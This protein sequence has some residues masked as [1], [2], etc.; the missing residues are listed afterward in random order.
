MDRLEA[1]DFEVYID[2]IAPRSDA[3]VFGGQGML[4]AQAT[5]SGRLFIP[6]FPLD[7]DIVVHLGFMIHHFRALGHRDDFILATHIDE[8]KGISAVG[9]AVATRQPKEAA[10]EDKE[11]Q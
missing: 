10:V 7:L 1:Y 11:T 4:K 9:M 3:L 5:K 6:V 8:K 2:G